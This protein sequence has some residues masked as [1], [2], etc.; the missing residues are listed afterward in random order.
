MSIRTCRP[1]FDL[2]GLKV[3]VCLLL[4]EEVPARPQGGT[5]EGGVRVAVLG[6]GEDAPAA[7][8]GGGT[9]LA[10]V[11]AVDVAD[12]DGDLVEDVHQGVGGALPDVHAPDPLWG[13]KKNRK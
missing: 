2:R 10:D 11:L 12:S 3:N 5:V 6:G 8:Q 13:G 1:H 9:V 4:S 7:A